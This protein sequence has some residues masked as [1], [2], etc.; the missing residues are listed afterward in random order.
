MAEA[1]EFDIYEK[2]AEDI[3]SAECRDALQ[4]LVNQQDVSKLSSAGRGFR[5]AVKYYLPKL[6]MAPIWHAFSYF[7]YV[8]SLMELSPSQEDKEV[9]E[10]VQGLL[11]PL[12][13]SLKEHVAKLPKYV[14]NSALMR[15]FEF[16]FV[17]KFEFSLVS[18]TVPGIHRCH[19][20]I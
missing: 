13:T 9:F 17:A 16:E 7:E 1:A 8:R 2:Y 11:S 12:E 20:H 14:F 15:V 4:D 18:F 5:E 6:L 10:Q 3:M 19:M